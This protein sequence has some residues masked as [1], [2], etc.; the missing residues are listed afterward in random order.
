MPCMPNCIGR[1]CVV[2]SPCVACARAG[3]GCEVQLADLQAALDGA[4]WLIMEVAL[5]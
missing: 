5:E 1:V 2:I 3:V 4:V